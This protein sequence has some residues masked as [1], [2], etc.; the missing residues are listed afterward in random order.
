MMLE[1]PR[2]NWGFCNAIRPVQ[3]ENACC[4][5]RLRYLAGL[6]PI[7]K[8]SVI[9]QACKLSVI[10]QFIIGKR[11]NKNTEKALVLQRNSKTQM[12]RL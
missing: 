1:S 9:L 11:E 10:L 12:Q 5:L 2:R 3:W 7:G 6:V 4:Q 8:L